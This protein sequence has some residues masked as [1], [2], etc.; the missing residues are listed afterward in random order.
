VSGL[1]GAKKAASQTTKA[2]SALQVQTSTSG[3]VLP[4][5][6]GTN[7]IAGNL[8]WFGNWIPTAHTSTSSSGGKGGG[9]SSSSTTSYTYTT[10]V[11]I[12]L[13]E[14]QIR[15]IGTVWN[16]QAQSTA[17]ALGFTVFG[18]ATPQA[19]WSWL[20]SFN[21][22]QA[23]PY[24]GIAYVAASALSLGSNTSL[25]NFNFEVLGPLAYAPGTVDDALPSDIV[26]D[27][28]TN[29]FHGA[30]FAG[31]LGDTTSLRN[32]SLA[33]SLFLS[34]IEDQQRTASSFMD[35]M[36]S[37]CNFACVWSYKQLNL[38]PYG[39]VPITTTAATRR[40]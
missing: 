38:I 34:P 25:P 37:W 15:G 9:G 17:A 36:A 12:M 3:Q 32:Y 4:L 10:G 35:D 20:S 26:T 19:P 1:F 11:I 30:G 2:V 23:I 27:Y 31:Y 18:G 21:P 40:T 8:G 33:R 39:D 14:G 24:N 22:A 6:W 5:L 29:A 16:E 28:L 13:T 7:L